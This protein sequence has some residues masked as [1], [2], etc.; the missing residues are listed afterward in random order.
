[1]NWHSVRGSGAPW[2]VAASP[3][4]ASSLLDDG[5][6][7]RSPILSYPLRATAAA[8]GAQALRPAVPRHD[9]VAT[10]R[11][12]WPSPIATNFSS[13]DVSACATSAKAS[14]SAQSC[15]SARRRQ[16]TTTVGRRGA[17]VLARAARSS[18]GPTAEAFGPGVRPDDGDVVAQATWCHKII[19]CCC[20]VPT[21]RATRRAHRGTVG[22][23]GQVYPDACI[24]R[25]GAPPDPANTPEMDAGRRHFGE[26]TFEDD[27]CAQPSHASHPPAG[28]LHF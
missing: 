9:R 27:L 4:P 15:C 12:S 1:M 23:R 14:A 13:S 11:F 22:S 21:T 17:R 7:V 2:S 24:L 10:A 25:R 16:A 26:W 18:P 8:G 28:G 20:T 19:S 3:R 5:L 6:R